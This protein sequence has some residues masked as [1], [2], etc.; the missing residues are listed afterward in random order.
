M[1]QIMND[2]KPRS[3]KYLTF[4]PTKSNVTN[5]NLPGQANAS[6]YHDSGYALPYHLMQPAYEIKEMLLKPNKA[7]MAR[8]FKQIAHSCLTGEK[9][10]CFKKQATLGLGCGRFEGKA[11]GRKQVGRLEE[12]LCDSFRLFDRARYHSEHSYDRVLNPFGTVVY[13][14]LIGAVKFKPSE[15]MSQPK[16]KNVPTQFLRQSEINYLNT[17]SSDS[18]RR[19]QNRER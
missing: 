8:V 6:L 5:P 12:K 13:L 19:E 9:R 10:V 2:T 4:L 1:T 14:L 18:K 17:T 15:K 7:S 16:T 11:I 3:N